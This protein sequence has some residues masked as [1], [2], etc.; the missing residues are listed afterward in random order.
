MTIHHQQPPIAR[1]T[2]APIPGP[3]RPPIPAPAPRRKKSNLGI[4]IGIGIVGLGAVVF[5]GFMILWFFALGSQIETTTV[6]GTENVALDRGVWTVSVPAEAPD[7][8]VVVT[9]G[10][11]VEIELDRTAFGAD[12]NDNTSD[13]V[14]IGQVVI[15]ADGTY[16]VDVDGGSAQLLF[17]DLGGVLLASG[18]L[19]VAFFVGGAIVCLGGVATLV[20]FIIRVM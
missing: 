19:W 15:P 4:G 1:P 18:L 20:A 5:V 8:R 3:V 16:T 10:D 12:D 11:G 9:D 6:T 2:G 7:T 13:L 17:T 14:R